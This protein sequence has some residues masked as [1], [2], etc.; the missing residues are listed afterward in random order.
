MSALSSDALAADLEQLRAILGD[1]FSAVSP[2]DWE[3]PTETRSGG[4]TLSQALCH[5]TAV[6]EAMQQGMEEALAGRPVVFPGLTRREELAGYNAQEIAARQDRPPEMVAE[7]LLA[8]LGQVATR[9]RQLSDAELAAPVPLPA[10]NRPLT[11]AQTIGNQLAH[12]GITHGAQLANG[13]GVRPLW[14][15]FSSEM[16]Q[17]QLTRFLHVVSCAYWPERGG[18]L[19]AGINFIVAGRGGGRWHVIVNPAGGSAGE[20]QVERPA[21]TMWFPS[22]HACCSL[23]TLQVGR[24]RS[25]LTGRVVGWGD[26]SLG[27]KFPSLFTPT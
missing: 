11:V 24:W 12:P 27:F 21:L 20:G 10:Y 23:F 22:P 2:A 6:A 26:L 16:M 9:T 14:Q 25:L 17:R 18:D 8:T 1:F 19:E 15:H 13:V 4:W 7:T 5:V 3:R